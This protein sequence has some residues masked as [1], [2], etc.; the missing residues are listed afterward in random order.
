[1]TM[2]RIFIPIVAAL[3]VAL[4]T[5]TILRQRGEIDRLG[6][7]IEALSSELKNQH[8]TLGKEQL[9]TGRQRLTPGELREF[10][11]DYAQR[12]EDLGVRLRR[13][14]SLSVAASITELSATLSDTPAP[15]PDDSIGHTSLA[16][17]ATRHFRWSDS[18]VEIDAA[19]V[20]ESLEWHLTS[21][22]TLYQVV[23]RVPYRWWIFRWGTKALRQEI[24]SSN[25]HTRLTYAEYLQIE[26]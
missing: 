20:D 12:I 14:E 2:R 23:H 10:C 16:P 15:L 11:P 5:A 9:S 8:S 26:N 22:D 25:P 19:L 6:E 1:M 13:V 4:G 24:R 3:V 18:W 21:R 7:N 17:Q